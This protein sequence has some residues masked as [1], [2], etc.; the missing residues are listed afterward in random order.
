MRALEPVSLRLLCATRLRT[1]QIAHVE[2]LYPSS[3]T[4]SWPG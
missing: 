1:D 2:H 3:I 4:I